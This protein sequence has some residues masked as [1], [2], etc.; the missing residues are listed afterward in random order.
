MKEVVSNFSFIQIAVSLKADI[1]PAVQRFRDA[2]Y[3]CQAVFIHRNYFVVSR[4][5]VLFQN[6]LYPFVF[7][8]KHDDIDLFAIF[9]EE[10]S[11]YFP[12]AHMGANHN[13]SGVS[14]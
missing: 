14:V 2:E 3:M 4:R 6:L 11:A 10:R 7:G 1:L 12:V 9:I 8:V 5:G 13:Y